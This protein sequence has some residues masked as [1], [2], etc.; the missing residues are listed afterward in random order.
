MTMMWNLKKYNIVFSIL[1]AAILFTAC[2]KN[3]DADITYPQDGNIKLIMSIVP[4]HTRSVSNSPVAE[5][6]S[7]LRIVVLNMDKSEIEANHY[8]ALNGKEE[9]FTDNFQYFYTLST[10]AGQK[11]FYLLANEGHVGEVAY[12]AASGVTLPAD[13]GNNISTVLN[14]FSSGDG[15]TDFINVMDAIYFTPSY[16]ADNG[17]IFIPYVSMYEETITPTP[18]TEYNQAVELTTYLVPVATKF[19]FIFNNYRAAGIEVSGVSLDYRNTQNYLFAHVGSL[20]VTKKFQGDSYYWIDWLAKVS[21]AMADITGS[22]QN[23]SMNNTYGWISDY[24][25]PGDQV[26]PRIFMASGPDDTFIVPG[27]PQPEND[28]EEIIPQ[29]VTIG[30]FFL[31]ESKIM[32]PTVGDTSPERQLYHITIGLTDLTGDGSEAP[33]F[34]NVAIENLYSLFR[35]TNVVVTLNMR[36]GEVEIYAEVADWVRQDIN[37]WLIKGDKPSGI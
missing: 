10:T 5:K 31:G 9:K 2:H 7:S 18:P 4:L 16:E 6:I 11:R 15:I 36:Q 22:S 17:E 34:T 29:T 19:T 37:G 13:L 23:G 3:G 28:D 25:M 8:V 20:D 24:E 35:N 33:D 30:P 26:Q 32:E 12:K 14:S 1:V 21:Q 27:A